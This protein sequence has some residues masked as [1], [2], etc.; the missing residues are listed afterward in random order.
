MK[1]YIKNIFKM[2]L[3]LF[4]FYLI[5][6]NILNCDPTNINRIHIEIQPQPKVNIPIQTI[7]IALMEHILTN[8]NTDNPDMGIFNTLIPMLVIFCSIYY[9]LYKKTKPITIIK[10]KPFMML[11]IQ[12]NY[13]IRYVV[14]N[15]TMEELQSQLDLQN[16]CYTVISETLIYLN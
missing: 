14:N 15:I 16:I 7:D 13:E 6:N 2:T 12:G 4:L 3:L 9:I 1:I 5:F 11:P 10:R 8:S